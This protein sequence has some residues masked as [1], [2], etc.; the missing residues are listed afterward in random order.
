MY[1]DLYIHTRIIRRVSPLV[2]FFSPAHRTMSTQP[3]LHNKHNAIATNRDT[4][5]LKASTITPVPC[6]RGRMSQTWLAICPDNIS[7]RSC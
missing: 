6:Q 7:L 2:L 3:R 1:V 4:S 5:H